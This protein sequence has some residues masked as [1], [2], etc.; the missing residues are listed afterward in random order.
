MMKKL[1]YFVGILLLQS[2]ISSSQIVNDGVKVFVAKDALLYANAAHHHKAGE[3]IN[4][5]QMVLEGNGQWHNFSNNKVFS[6]SSAGTVTFNAPQFSFEGNTTAFPHLVFKGNGV[7]VLKAKTEVRLSL[8]IEDAEVQVLAP[9]SLTILNS[10]PLSLFRNKGF[11]NTSLG[12]DGSFLRNMKANEEY[13]FPMGTHSLMRFVTIKPKDAVENAIAISFVD[14][15]PNLVGY[16][17]FNKSKSITEINDAYY[18]LLKRVAGTSQIDLAFHIP[19]SEKYSSLVTWG[20]NAQWNSALSSNN[21]NNTILAPGLTQTLVH[22]NAD[23]PIGG[24]V[25]F[26]LAQVANAGPLEIYNAFSPDGDGKN[27]TWE[28]KNIDLFPDNELKIFDRSGNLVFRVNGYNSSKYWDGQNVA[29]GT[30][31]YILRAK[32]DGKDQYFKGAITMVKN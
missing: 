23:L 22:K 13:L 6:Q 19:S 3:I 27:D 5:G 10:D 12:A 21:Q 25:A 9:E 31:I 24:N 1:F 32:I 14:K 8:D 17:R 26:A 30:Y 29:S 16:S 4:N 15:D 11:I 28:V 18:H 2:N 7:Y 20:K